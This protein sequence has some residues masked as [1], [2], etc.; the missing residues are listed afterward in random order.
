M[1]FCWFC[2]EGAHFVSSSSI[3]HI[4]GQ[5]KMTLYG[6]TS[7]PPAEDMILIRLHFHKDAFNKSSAKGLKDR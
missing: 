4:K 6:C 3:G 1:P 5:L 2:H 7:D